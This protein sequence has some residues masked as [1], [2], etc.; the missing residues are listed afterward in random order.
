MRRAL[1]VPFALSA[2]AIITAEWMRAPGWILATGVVLAAVFV[3]WSTRTQA[4]RSA[5]AGVRAGGVIEWGAAVVAALLAATVAAE[6][7][8]LWRIDRHWPQAREAAVSAASRRLGGELDGAVRLARSLADKAALASRRSDAGAFDELEALVAVGGPSHGVVLFDTAGHA[9]AWAGVH[10]TVLRA[11]GPDLS[12]VT[13][14]FYLWLVARRQTRTGTAAA[15]VLLAR[16]DDVPRAGDALTDQF[17]E[18][19]G[20]GLRF[21]DPRSA[22]ADSDVFD[23]VQ[24]GGRDTLFAVQP[25]P[26]GQGTAYGRQLAASRQL[27]A[28]LVL[29]VLVIA[30]SLAT[31]GGLPVAVL[32]ASAALAALARAPLRETFGPGSVFWPATYYHGLLG[33]FS[34]SAGTLI[35]TGVVVFAAGSALW[36]RGRRRSRWAVAVA[37]LATVASPYVLQT[38]ARGITPPTSGVTIGLW[39]TWQVAIV[40]AASSVVLVAAALVR[41]PALP[42][43]AGVWPYLAGGLALL[44]AGIGLWVWQPYGGWPDWY[45]YVW[46]PAL[47]LAIRPMPFRGTLATIAVVAGSSGAL[48]TWRAATEGRMALAAADVESL[49]DQAD[50]YAVMLLDRLIHE[51]PVEHAPRAPGDLFVLWH[52]SEL[53]AQ[54]YPAALAVWGPDGSREL[55]LELARLDVPAA[56]VQ[57]VA[58]EAR[59]EA[60]PIVRPVL[61]V[62]GLFG[63][64]AIPLAASRVLTIVV[65]PHTQLITPSPQAR[66]LMGAA[67]EPEPPYDLLLAPAPASAVPKPYVQWRRDGWTLRGDRPINLPGGARHAH[68]EIDL[69]G[70]S[71]LLQRGLLVLA[72]DVAVLLV[73]WLLVETCAGRA[74]A[75]LA[76]WWSQARRSL[77]LR[78]SVSLGLFFVLP[79]LAFA[80]W[81]LGRFEE[82]FRSARELLLERTLRDATSV[83]VADSAA[84]DTLSADSA[85]VEASQRVDAE[86]FLTR[87]G[88]LAAT[89][90]PVLA[91]LGLADVLVPSDVYARLALGDEVSAT[92]WQGAATTETLVGYRLLARADA[93]AVI[94]AAPDVAG[95]RGLKRREEDLAIAVLVG[96]V[97]GG[98]FALVLSGLAARALARPL[99][100]LR[101]SA[102]AVATGRPPALASA[103]VPAELEPIRSALAQAA[104]DVE[105]GQRAQRVLAWGEMAR[106]VAHEIK[107]PLTPIRLGIQHLLKVSRE[108]P[109]EVASALTPTGE[110]ILAEIDRLDAIARTFSR[111][112]LPA[113]EGMPLETVDLRAA[114]GDVVRLY[115]MGEGK[116]RWEEKVTAG[117][118]AH[119]RRDELVEVLVNLCE[120]AR[121]AGATTVTITARTAKGRAVV[122]VRDDG[123]GIPPEVLPRIFE[124]RFSTTTSGSGLGLAIAKRLVESW[125]GTIGVETRAGRGTL[126]RLDLEAGA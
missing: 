12:A 122:E 49:G 51:M 10:R 84:S 47:L 120:N 25:V 38:L 100:R 28:L 31:R 23:Y 71:S 56:A 112:A 78:L 61:Q 33:P 8:A 57:R 30:A 96:V 24:P 43:H 102:L 67:G 101:A 14:P 114:V 93:G 7:R 42:A 59:E 97:A 27:A 15:A 9:R 19:T 126:I 115:R 62:P 111:F 91:D 46:A 82:Q 121:D 63:V 68:A 88:A 52:R 58:Q 104:T 36:R 50:P 110:R 35:I 70:P 116:P 87:G 109:D 2:A 34:A 53:G 55:S 90:A 37:L 124:P 32:V 4:E 39:L 118:R 119:A 74:R 29:A 16:S 99:Q 117:A 75:A 60:L 5:G 44:A 92:A 108:K 48:L 17:A 103:D 20:V 72:L 1:S 86:L 26:P 66:L 41:G 83:L 125:G 69:R 123:H 113:A 76:A 45:Q 65:G 79:A 94:V 64:A 11:S 81:T 105:A 77:R 21:L 85:I 73:L 106:Q 80:I 13:T 6:S 22:P 54:G 98:L 107:N 3:A 89:S 18:A 95:D 40:L